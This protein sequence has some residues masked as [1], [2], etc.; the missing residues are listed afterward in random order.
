MSLSTTNLLKNKIETR[1][2][3][4]KSSMVSLNN[5]VVVANRVAGAITAMDRWGSVASMTSV[6]KRR[7]GVVLETISNPTVIM[8]KPKSLTF[9][10]S[11]NRKT[12]NL[13]YKIEAIIMKI[14]VAFKFRINQWR[15]AKGLETRQ[16]VAIENDINEANSAGSTQL[17]M[18]EL[19]KVTQNMVRLG[20]DMDRLKKDMDELKKVT[21]NVVDLEK[22]L[23]V[24]KQ[25]NQRLLEILNKKFET[26]ESK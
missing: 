6:I 24:I 12:N 20:E 3:S 25:Q 17:I 7:E 26:R 18:G 5:E 8:S 11:P 19:T 4:R 10:I 15:V 13:E 22:D 16:L 2:M 1:I 14:E 23:K 9:F 21:K